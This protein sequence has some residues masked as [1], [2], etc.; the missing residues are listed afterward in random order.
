M[1]QAFIDYIAMKKVVC[2]PVY[3][4]K[5][6]V[7]LSVASTGIALLSNATYDYPVIRYGIIACILIVVYI[8]KNKLIQI[9]KTIRQ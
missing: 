1:V 6:I 7:W 4:M 9:V 5:L 3:N 2:E 8:F